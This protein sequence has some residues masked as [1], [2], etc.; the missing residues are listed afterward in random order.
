MKTKLITLLM[1]PFL[2]MACQK[3][4]LTSY[5]ENNKDAG[6]TKD[7][8]VEVIDYCGDPL[9]ATLTNSDE[10]V[11]AGTVTVGND[12]NFLYVTYELTGNYWIDNA[13]LYVGPADDVPGT[14]YG[15]GTGSFSPWNFPYKYFPWNPV[16]TKTFVVDLST[17]E[18][19][20]LVVA[21]AYVQDVSTGD[22]YF[23][24]GKNNNKS[25]GFYFDYCKQSCQE[26]TCE[27]AFAWGDEY[28]T[29]FIDIP[30]LNG[31]RWGWTNGPLSSGIY[32]FELWAGAGQC[33]LSKGTLVGTL[34]ID[35]DGSIATVTYSMDAG[36][37]LNET[38]LYIGD[39]PVPQKNN[40]QYT[41]A[42]G[43]Y[44]YKHDDLNGANSDTYVVD[45]LSG[46]IYVIGHAVAC[47][48]FPTSMSNLQ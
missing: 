39:E 27:T 41:V 17:L 18:D 5:E 44:P 33:D 10:T 31:N 48:E 4:E 15:N 36:F 22:Y 43:Q 38:H 16:Q 30:Y 8:E 7:S 26:P 32:D 2:F 21:Y 40:G 9:V 28:A 6:T 3:T 47:G 42:P 20:F 12:E 23:I 14:L 46:D 13:A 37:T 35:Y 24:Y 29:C 19:C 34:N 11:V 25:P 45:G 1:L